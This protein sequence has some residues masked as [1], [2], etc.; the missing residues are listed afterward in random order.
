MKTVNLLTLIFLTVLFISCEPEEKD[1]NKLFSIETTD[2]KT[3][4]KTGSTIDFYINN[5][6][7]KDISAVTYSVNGE[8]IEGTKYTFNSKLGGKF[9]RAQFSY[10]NKTVTLIKKIEILAKSAPRLVKFEVVN[11]YPHDIN[12]YTQGLEFYEGELY[13]S[14][15]QYG[16]STLRKVDYKTG[17]VKKNIN[18]DNKYFGEGIT[19]LN[20]QLYQLTWREQVGFVYNPETFD[21]V[22]TFKYKKSN[23][24][25][26]LC[27]DGNTIYKSDGTQ[28]I[29]TLNNETLTEYNFIEI[30]DNNGKI[31][32]V[33]ELEW[34]NGKIFANI[35]KEKKLHYFQH[36]FKQL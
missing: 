12:A 17:E 13:E 2:N 4:Y 21:K 26:G 32:S 25:W 11:T 15:G 10:N 18:L 6:K 9:I 16:E 23:E 34:I 28:R 5:K 33:N 30:Y 1:M 36:L 35:Y 7:N 29:W 24:G 27:N 19:F 20:N 14:T 3:K 22:K 8:A 31:N